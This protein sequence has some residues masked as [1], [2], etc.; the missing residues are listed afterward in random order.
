MLEKRISFVN[1]YSSIMILSF[2]D[3]NELFLEKNR[4]TYGPNL[5]LCSYNDKMKKR[6]LSYE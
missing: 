4:R 3:N 2:G 6:D 5:S 1:H